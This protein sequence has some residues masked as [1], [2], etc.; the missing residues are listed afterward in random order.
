MIRGRF[1][2]R[3]DGRLILG[4]AF[5]E[6]ESALKPGHVYE[7]RELCGVLSVNELGPSCASQPDSMDRFGV[8]DAF[9]PDTLIR[10]GNRHLCTI[11]EA[12]R[13][14]A[15]IEEMR[16]GEKDRSGG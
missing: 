3:S 11:T 13:A 7:I 12:E 9:T 1:F 2:V 4:G 5:T 16:V 8:T 14:L 10:R 15:T 6:G